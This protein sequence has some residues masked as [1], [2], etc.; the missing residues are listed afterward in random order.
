MKENTKNIKESE[1]KQ[2]KRD[3]KRI[4]K[5]KEVWTKKKKLEEPIN[6]MLGKIK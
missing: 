6:R 5:I 4:L 2:A 1:Y 3:R